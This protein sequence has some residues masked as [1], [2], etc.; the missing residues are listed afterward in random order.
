MTRK[1][2]LALA[3]FLLLNTACKPATSPTPTV[4]PA[5]TMAVLTSA[6]TS[7]ATTAPPLPTS[8]PLATPSGQD[9]S[10]VYLKDDS[11]WLWQAG[12]TRLLTSSKPVFAPRISPDGRLVAFLRQVDE[13]H[14]ELW[15]IDIDGGNERRLVNIDDLNTIGA[16]VLEP[17]ALA[18]VPHHFEW[19]PNSHALAFNTRQVFQGPGLVINDDF[20]LVDADTQQ[21][22]FVLLAGWGGEFSL[23]PDGSLVALSTPTNVVLSKLDGSDWRSV[24]SYEPVLTYSDYRFY[25]QPVWSPDGKRL[26]VA[27]PPADPLADP[28][29]PTALWAID[30]S[31][32]PAQHVHSLYAVPY[33]DTSITFA[34]DLTH[35]LYLNDIDHGDENWREIHIA[36]LDGSADQVVHAG[37]LVNLT[38][39]L[40]DSR[41]FTFSQGEDQIMY[42]GSP[43]QPPALL[44]AGSSGIHFPRWVDDQRYL[45]LGQSAA[46][47]ELRLGLSGAGSL[48]LDSIGQ[49]PLAF[50]FTRLSPQ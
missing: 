19:V 48:T 24:L 50:D 11:L 36:S 47:L 28:P 45:Y 29:A 21:V 27:I 30:P 6:P 26:S 34:P 8:V 23:S 20:N 9:L 2:L 4:S 17:N 40:P 3:L 25:A 12:K 46:G 33:F 5:S 16:S 22:T 35:L 1:I 37:P 43:D 42:L 10:V 7:T 15:A 18:V 49:P 38:G 13:V 31:A 44:S 32:G 14:L 39:W 41:H